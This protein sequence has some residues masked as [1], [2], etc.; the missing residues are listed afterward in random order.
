MFGSHSSSVLLVSFDFLTSIEPQ[1]VNNLDVT[2][3]RFCVISIAVQRCRLCTGLRRQLS[4]FLSSCID[5]DN[6][7]LIPELWNVEIPDLFH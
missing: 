5:S 6:T 4:E 1:L 7:V 3:S 2:R